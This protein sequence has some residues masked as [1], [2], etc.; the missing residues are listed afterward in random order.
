MM[1]SMLS[2]LQSLSTFH[3]YVRIGLY[4]SDWAGIA[5]ARTQ[6]GFGEPDE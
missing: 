6:G 1:T 5:A 2:A 4:P 3:R